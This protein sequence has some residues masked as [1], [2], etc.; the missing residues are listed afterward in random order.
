MLI[1]GSS[2]YY[3][4][5][6]MRILYEFIKHDKLKLKYILNI[7]DELQFEWHKDTPPEVLFKMKQL[8]EDWPD[9]KVPVVAEIEYTSTA[10]ADKKPIK[11]LEEWRNVCNELGEN[12]TI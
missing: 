3:L 5:W 4:K 11:N 8:M 2:A 12:K 10:W 9:T 7:H 6:K 1:Q